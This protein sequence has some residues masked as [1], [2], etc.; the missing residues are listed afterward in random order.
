MRKTRY[1]VVELVKR[2]GCADG[3][4]DIFGVCLSYAK[5]DKLQKKLQGENP[6]NVYIIKDLLTASIWMK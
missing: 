4:G 5:A 6:H 2:S 3:I 1:V